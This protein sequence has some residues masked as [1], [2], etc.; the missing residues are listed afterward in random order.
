MTDCISLRR[1]TSK[2]L[3]LF[4]LFN[5]LCSNQRRTQVHL[6]TLLLFVFVN[7]DL[8]TTKHDCTFIVVNMQI[9]CA[10]LEGVGGP[11]PPPPPP[12]PPTHGPELPPPPLP[13]T[14]KN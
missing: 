7:S 2:L 8:M 12:P 3:Q 10:D 13:K 11:D 1:G 6:P 5:K 9:S 4:D 14:K